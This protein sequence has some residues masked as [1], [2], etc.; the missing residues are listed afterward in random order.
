MTELPASPPVTGLAA[1]AASGGVATDGETAVTAR[2]AVV[3][4]PRAVRDFGRIA[5]PR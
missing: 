4:T 1:V 5:L 3:A 2:T